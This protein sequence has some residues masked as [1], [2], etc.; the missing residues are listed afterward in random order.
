[1][2]LTLV[3]VLFLASAIIFAIDFFLGWAFESQYGPYRFRLYSLCFA[4]MCV[5]FLLWHGGK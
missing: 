1:M 4:M 3:L 2:T 5:A